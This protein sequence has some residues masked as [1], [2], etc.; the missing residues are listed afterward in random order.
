MVGDLHKEREKLEGELKDSRTRLTMLE[1]VYMQKTAA[2]VADLI[3]SIN[4]E[5]EKT[6]MELF[7]LVRG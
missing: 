7:Y 5:L 3:A 1:N 2:P 4:P 6:I